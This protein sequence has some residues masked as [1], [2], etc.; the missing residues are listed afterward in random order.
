MRTRSLGAPLRSWSHLLSALSFAAALALVTGCPPAG[1]EPGDDDDDDST[2]GDDDSTAGD[3]DTTAGDDDTGDDD[4]GDDDTTAGDDDTTAAPDNDGDGYSVADGD[5]D[6]SD[7]TLT[8]ADL[9]GDGHSTCD[10]DCDDNDPY[11]FPGASEY[12]DGLDNDCD[13]VVPLNEADDDGDGFMICAG[14]CDDNDPDLHPADLD[15][16]GFTPCDGDCDDS[17]ADTYPGATEIC[18]GLD[19]DCD[20]VLDPPEADFDGDGVPICAADCDDSD[21]LTYPGAPEQCDGLDN[22]CDGDVDE[23]FG[24]D[25]DGDGYTMCQGDCDDGDPGIYPGA[26]EVCDGLDSDCDGVLP[27]IEQDGDGDGD[28]S[29]SDCDDADPSVTSVDGDGDGY[30]TCDGDCDDGDP[31]TSPGA[32]D[33]VGDGVDN[34][35]DGIDGVDVDQDGYASLQSGG[36]DCDDNNGQLTPA[37]NDGDGFS[38][39]DGDCNDYYADIYPGA[40]EV[41]GDGTDNDCDGAV[42]EPANCDCPPQGS[43]ASAMDICY[44]LVGESSG[45]APVQ[46]NML[47]GYGS[48]I[49]PQAGCYLFGLHTGVMHEDPAQ[50]GADTGSVTSEWDFT[51][52]GVNCGSPPPQGYDT[53]YNLTWLSLTLEVPPNTYSFLIDFMFVSSEYEEWVCTDYNDTFEMYLES[54]ALDPA[55]Y[56]DRDGDTIP[57]GNISFDGNGKPITVNSNFFIVDD[58]ATMWNIEGF[59][60]QGFGVVP[61]VSQIPCYGAYGSTNDAGATGW[62]T[63][64][65]PV[66]PGE[67]ITLKFSIWDEGDGIYDSVVFIDNFRWDTTVVSDPITN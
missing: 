49:A 2:A 18:D 5:C 64:T 43:F 48:A 7:P 27:W 30:S 36:D 55:S 61:G 42:D 12:C 67:T 46:Y 21:P 8:P 16:D 22:D 63:T 59:S 25:A 23:G 11:L 56:P 39:C 19:N 29:C 58:C 52:Q 65:A 51:G 9:D 54:T 57:E 41:P 33:A 45:G 34:N 50:Y 35:C 38:P 14:D 1:W 24:A 28:P 66:T 53:K 32:S 3:D 31:A 4:T 40:Y 62:L 6:D 20:G 47:T 60:G 17:S 15:L 44:G 13:G 10:G 26:P 37:D